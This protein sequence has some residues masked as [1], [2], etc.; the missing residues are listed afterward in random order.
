MRELTV[1]LDEDKFQALEA[2]A[3]ETGLG[4]ADR[5]LIQEIDRLLLNYRG[6][7]VS[8][9]LRRHLK[10]SIDENRRL[11]ERLAQ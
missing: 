10:A 7:A 3:K 8:A 4:A 6:A 5:L 9:E 11:L 1:R 2:I